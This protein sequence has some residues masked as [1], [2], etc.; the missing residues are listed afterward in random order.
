MCVL[1]VVSLMYSSCA[2]SVLERPFAIKRKTSC[3]RVVC[4]SN[5]VGAV[6]RGCA[7][8]V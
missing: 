5:S 2:I 8:T 4:S 6:G 7:R 3:S 1:T